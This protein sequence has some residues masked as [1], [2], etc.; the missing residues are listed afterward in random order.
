MQEAFPNEG[1]YCVTA[2]V[3]YDLIVAIENLKATIPNELLNKYKSIVSPLIE[4]VMSS[5][6]HHAFISNHL[7]TAAAALIKWNKLTGDNTHAKGT[8]IVDRIFDK[9]S[10]EGWFL[11]YEGADPG[12]QTLCINYLAD[13]YISSKE[14]DFLD[15]IDKSINF[16]LHCTHPD[17]SFGGIYGSRNTRFYY[18]GGIE[19]FADKLK[20]AKCLADYMALSISENKTVNLDAIDE[21]NLIPMFNS[22][23]F[24]AE[25]CKKRDIN[26]SY[27]RSRN[28]VIPCL[29]TKE[30]TKIYP[31]AGVCINKGKT[32]YSI[33]SLNKPDHQVLTF[34][35]VKSG[36]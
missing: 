5:D 24:A 31:Q 2:L 10:N 32:T 12:Y 7:A 3:A 19:Y 22:F 4:Y 27:D 6:E 23:C 17:G 34:G 18:P 11:E 25:N 35:F 36:K 29:S 28:N 9:Q 13:I 20:S 8:S 14:L 33:I 15:K 21:P 1:S 26:K 16:L 30:W